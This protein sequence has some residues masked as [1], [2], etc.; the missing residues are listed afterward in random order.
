MKEETGGREGRDRRGNGWNKEGK[1][2]VYG[3]DR[4]RKWET[5]I[6]VRDFF[7]VCADIDFDI[8][9]RDLVCCL[10]FVSV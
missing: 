10:H 6:R 8:R 1:R 4:Q 5:E 9:M 3:D 2:A 7:F